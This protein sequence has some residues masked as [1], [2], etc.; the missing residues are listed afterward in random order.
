VKKGSAIV[1]LFIAMMAAG[2]MAIALAGTATAENSYK[3]L[4]PQSGGGQ[5]C[6]S[7]NSGQGITDTGTQVI[8]WDCNNTPP[9]RG[10]LVNF[11]TYDSRGVP[12]YIVVNGA[13][14]MCM[15]ALDGSFGNGTRI[16]QE[17][18]RLTTNQLWSIT[19]VDSHPTYIFRNYASSF[20][21]GQARCLDIPGTALGAQAQ[22][23]DCTGSNNQKFMVS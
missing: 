18:C 12:L 14:H 15:A 23:W 9:E 3:W 21:N 1:R 10:W 22:L 4:Q 16:E 8:Q 13:S 7:L 5:R 6:L 11:Y 19:V 17:G 20:V 2:V